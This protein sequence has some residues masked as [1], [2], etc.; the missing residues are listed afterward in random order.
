MVV[1]EQVV[2]TSCQYVDQV[3]VV[4]VLYRSTLAESSA[5]QSIAK[6]FAHFLNGDNQVDLVIVNNGP[7]YVDCQAD[8][9][10]FRLH[11]IEQLDNPGVS[12]AYNLAG[13]LAGRLQKQWLLVL[14]QDTVLPT[15]FWD[16]YN[17]SIDRYPTTPIHAPKLWSGDVLISPCKYRFYRGTLLPTNILP[18]LHSMKGRNVLNS[19]LLIRVEAFHAVGGYNESVRLYFS[20]FV[21]FDRIKTKHATFAVV[22]VDLIHDLSSTDYS[23]Q[24]VASERFLLYCQGG[25]AAAEGSLFRSIV[26]FITIGARSLL[27]GKRFGTLLFTKTFLRTWFR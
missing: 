20:D 23:S 1:S 8:G 10:V 5:Y 27:M 16:S 24:K 7:T 22:N 4:I 17:E 19:G 15:N 3:L 13:Q 18:G 21:F 12:K 11:Y 9:A 2:N 25:H 14:D 6:A 26:Y